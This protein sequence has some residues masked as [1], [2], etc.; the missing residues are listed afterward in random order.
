MSNL[1]IT[2]RCPEL[3]RLAAA[4]E[5]LSGVKTASVSPAAPNPV[6]PAVPVP[7]APVPVAPAP[8]VPLAPAPTYTYEQIG[9]AGAD[10]A[11]SNPA[12]LPELMAL[13]QRYGVAAVTEL[14]EEQLGAFATE[15]R[16]LGAKL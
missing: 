12:R 3:E 9:K 11:G 13:L 14:K 5:S 10:L 7:V 6:A 2:I 16:G 4:L 15:L 8:A 1:E